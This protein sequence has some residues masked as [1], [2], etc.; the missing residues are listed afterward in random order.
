MMLDQPDMEVKAPQARPTTAPQMPSSGAKTALMPHRRRHGSLITLYSRPDLQK[1]GD[2]FPAFKFQ[3]QRPTQRTQ[4]HR[5]NPCRMYPRRTDLTECALGICTQKH[6]LTERI[7]ERSI[8]RYLYFLTYLLTSTHT[9]LH[10]CNPKC[11]ISCRITRCQ[12]LQFRHRK[13]EENHLQH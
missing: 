1:S 12:M 4:P 11:I 5:I 6:T 10:I 13:L 3:I 7:I 2:T 8:Y 9:L